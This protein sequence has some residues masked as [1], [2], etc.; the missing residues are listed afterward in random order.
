MNPSTVTI[1]RKII[2]FDADCFY[3]AVEMRDNPKLRNVP[4]AVGGPA[5]RR[6]VIATCNYEARAFGV[7]SAM[8]TRRALQ[9]CPQLVVVFPDF[10]RYKSASQ[11]IF[12]IYREYSDLIEPLSL[13]E[14][15]V[16]VSA[17]SIHRGSATLIAQEIRQRVREETGLVVSAGVAPNKFLA[18]IASDWHK[19]DGLYVIRPQDVDVFVAQLP[20]EKLFGVGPRTAEKMHRLRLFTCADV[21]ARELPFL[22]EQFGKLGTALYQSARGIDNREVKS[23]RAR[24]SISVETTFAQDLHGFKNCVDKLPALHTDLIK[25]IERN[26]A[27]NLV[28][29][30]FVK[31]RMADFKVRTVEVNERDVSITHFKQLLENACQKHTGAIRL[32][33]LGVRLRAPDTVAQLDLL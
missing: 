25:R 14:A 16:D 12:N 3:A 29:K 11:A 20:I 15:Y 33:G 31:L 10:T 30:T 32:I 13:D 4:L 21:R 1:Q 19:P 26:Q 23:H 6:G 7:R 8:P 22:R 9:L 24:K 27:L 2:H 18:K 28:P 17:C 5:D